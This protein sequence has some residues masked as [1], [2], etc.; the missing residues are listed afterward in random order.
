MELFWR[1]IFNF[2]RDLFKLFDVGKKRKFQVFFKIM[3][4][5]IIFNNILC[6]YNRLSCFRIMYNFR[7]ILFG[8]Q[9][10]IFSLLVSQDEI[11]CI[12]FRKRCFFFFEMRFVVFGFQYLG[13]SWGC[14]QGLQV[15]LFTWSRFIFFFLNVVV[16]FFEFRFSFFVIGIN[17]SFQLLNGGMG[18]IWVWNKVRMLNCFL[19]DLGL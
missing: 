17:E 16:V 18:V 5:L 10:G 12:C 11:I 3:V 2:F 7:I 14:S 13:G 8:Q 19:E 15:M 4:R 6:I 1:N 9:F